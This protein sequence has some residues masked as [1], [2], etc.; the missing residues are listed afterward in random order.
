MLCERPLFNVSIAAVMLLHLVVS[1]NVC[2]Y[3]DIY[4]RSYFLLFS[5]VYPRHSEEVVTIIA[6]LSADTIMLTPPSSREAALAAR[7]KFI[8]PE[9]DMMTLLNVFRAYRKVQKNKVRSMA[10]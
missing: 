8:A 5:S 1:C 2:A 3:A 6:L 9:G 10:E 4:I 7:Q